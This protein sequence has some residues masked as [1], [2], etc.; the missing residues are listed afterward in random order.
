[1]FIILC[2]VSPLITCSLP[3]SCP[4][5]VSMKGSWAWRLPVILQAVGSVAMLVFLYWAPQSPRWL[6]S[7]GRE[8]EA[9]SLLSYY[10]SPIQLSLPSST[11]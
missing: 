3:A 4:A 6:V 2:A 8:A 10:V 11:D 1:M 5:V 9:L 7:K